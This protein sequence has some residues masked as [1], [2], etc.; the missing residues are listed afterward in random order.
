MQHKGVDNGI[1]FGSFIVSCGGFNS[2][3]IRQWSRDLKHLI[4]GKR[5]TRI[6]GLAFM[7]GPKHA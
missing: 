3:S 6:T 1:K 4:S 2:L 5:A 7:S